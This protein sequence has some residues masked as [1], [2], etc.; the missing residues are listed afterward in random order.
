MPLQP[1]GHRPHGGLHS[2]NSQKDP[3]RPAK[4]SGCRGSSQ[5]VTEPPSPTQP[6]CLPLLT[7]PAAISLWTADTGTPSK[8]GK[9]KP[10]TLVIG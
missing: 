4:V 2:P 9:A 5:R 7:S 10:E 1:P 3:I 8:E 6:K